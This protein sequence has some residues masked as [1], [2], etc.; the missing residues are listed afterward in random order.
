MDGWNK[1]VYEQQVVG[2]LMIDEYLCGV[3]LIRKYV[4]SLTQKYSHVLTE[5]LYKTVIQQ[6]CSCLTQ[7]TRYMKWVLGALLYL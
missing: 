1:T 2:G 3:D 6:T 7:S 5:W 4:S